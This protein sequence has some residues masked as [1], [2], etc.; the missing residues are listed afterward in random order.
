MIVGDEDVVSS[1]LAN[2]DMKT[3][4]KA[5]QE[6]LLMLDNVEICVGSSASI[7]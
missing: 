1:K 3:R 6:V 7:F 5:P 4:I 2:L